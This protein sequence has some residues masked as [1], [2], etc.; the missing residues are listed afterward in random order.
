[1][2]NLI[3]RK[4]T[5]D[6]YHE[7]EL[8]TMRAFWNIHSPGCSEHLL[9][10]IL[11]NSKDY[12]PELSRIAEIT[13]RIAGAI[14]YSKAK[15]VSDDGTEHSVLT[16]GP[17]SIEPN[18]QDLGIGRRLMEETFKLAKEAGYPGIIIFGEADYYPKIGFKPAKSFEITDSEGNACDSMMAYPLDEDAFSKIHGKFY[19]SPDFM[20]CQDEKAI[21]E[22]EKDFPQYR[23]I[24]LKDGFMTLG[25]KRIAVVKTLK[26]RSC[27][28]YFWELEIE[29]IF[30]NR[31]GR[32]PK[33]GDIVLFEW[34]RNGE[35][36]I[37][38]VCKDLLLEDG[39]NTVSG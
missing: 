26:S 8:M 38:K 3:I 9:V 32:I 2:E 19:E 18:L 16:F 5:P 36:Y 17:L 31:L 39:K 24:K 29:A 4:E 6:D 28:L 13:D 23:K 30:D 37:T 12:L 25:S 22:L 11:R 34:K 15:V 35:S 14:F 21:L 7:T 20:A 33:A 10:R 1:M 27:I